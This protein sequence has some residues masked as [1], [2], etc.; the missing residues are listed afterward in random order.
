MK[1]H[2]MLLWLFLLVF[3]FTAGAQTPPRVNIDLAKKTI[4]INDILF[5][6]NST[7]DEYEKHLGKPDRIEQKRGVDQYF[8]YDKL[9]ISLSIDDET[10][11]VNEIYINYS[12][13]GNRKIAKEAYKG[14]LTV[15]N[16]A[17]GAQITHK[18]MSKL[19][20]LDFVELMNGYF[21]SPMNELSLLLYYPEG[22]PY[23][24]LKQFGVRFASSNAN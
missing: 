13:D 18:E 17:V 9:G 14:V 10:E 16:Q 12:H 3:S 4:S 6:R 21:V 20:K 5:T 1:K 7:I 11:L 19:V 8:A 24:T 23:K 22:A 2:L 15:N